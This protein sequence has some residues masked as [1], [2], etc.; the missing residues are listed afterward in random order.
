M[1]TGLG[2]IYAS[3][4]FN[5]DQDI[6]FG[7]DPEVCSIV[8]PN[9]AP[10]VSKIHCQIVLNSFG[11]KASVIDCDS[12]FGTFLNGS[13]LEPGQPY[14]LQDGDVIQFGAGNI[15]RINL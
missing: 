5:L 3:S 10:G 8:F 7:R 14:A 13:R 12:S 15:F 9:G 6:I 4:T 2:G 11:A 1:L